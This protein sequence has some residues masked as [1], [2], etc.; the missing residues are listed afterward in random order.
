MSETLNR[1]KAPAL[2]HY[3]P[4]RGTLGAPH[5]SI[6]PIARTALRL[7]F[8][9][10]LFWVLY[11][12]SLMIFMLFFF[13]QYLLLQLQMQS[14]A[15][16]G[17]KNVPEWIDKFVRPILKLDGSGE[18]YRFFIGYQGYMIMIILALAGSILVGN[19]LQFGSLAFYLSKPLS[20]FHYLAGK[21][22]AVGVFI[23]LMT[24]LPAVVLYVQYSLVDDRENYFVDKWQ[25]L[26]GIFGY[27]AVLTC[28]L[29]LMLLATAIWVQRTVPMIM[30]WT[31]LFLFC[32]LLGGAL[33]NWLGFSR[34]WRLIDLW[35]S[36]VL[37]GNVCLQVDVDLNTQPEWYWA[38]MVLAG[39]SLLCL[40]YLILRIRAVEVVK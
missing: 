40:T 22:L 20:R 17:Q 7:I 3:R 12:L 32:R 39:V 36:T 35:N 16:G 8:H 13:G 23:N 1:E 28:T 9:R 37:L 29:S 30:V 4:W 21:A 11:G 33:I 27:G 18:S 14:A 15:S 19:D 2:L 38:A 6:W 5:T 10:K 31:T 24:T 25:L 26:L 34:Y